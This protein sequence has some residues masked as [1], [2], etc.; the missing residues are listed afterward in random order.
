[1]SHFAAQ[2]GVNSHQ[3]QADLVHTARLIEASG[4]ELERFAWC[5]LHGVLR[6]KTLVASAA[7]DAMLGEVG[8][9]STVMFKDTSDRMAF[10][11]FEPGGAADLPGFEG[12]SN[13]MLL[14]DP[15]SYRPLPWAPKTAW[16]QG[17]LWFPDGRPVAFDTRRILQQALQRLAAAG[18]GLNCGLEV[19]L[20]IYRIEDDMLDPEQAA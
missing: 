10:K 18:Y 12:A 2:C 7:V 19:E 6:S 20:H 17:E 11:V 5:D 16:L 1:M 3:R 13:L 8:M 14:V 15:A 9:V 4:V